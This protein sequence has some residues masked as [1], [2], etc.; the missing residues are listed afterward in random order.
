MREEP[1]VR[2]GPHV[3]RPSGEQLS[4]IPRR[5]VAAEWTVKPPPAALIHFVCTRFPG[6]DGRKVR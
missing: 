6:A 5:I 2:G 3:L 1:Q 4:E